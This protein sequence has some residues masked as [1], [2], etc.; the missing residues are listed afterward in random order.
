MGRCA[1][2]FPCSPGTMQILA[3][4]RIRW[5]PTICIGRFHG[6]HLPPGR[7]CRERA[8]ILAGRSALWAR[9]SRRRETF[10]REPW[11]VAYTV[12]TRHSRREIGKWLFEGSL[13]RSAHLLDP[14]HGAVSS[15][16]KR[17]TCPKP[18]PPTLENAR[19]PG[20]LVRCWGF[21]S[22]DTLERFIGGAPDA[23]PSSGEQRWRTQAHSH[24]AS[25]PVTLMRPESA[26][27]SQPAQ[28]SMAKEGFSPERPP[29]PRGAGS[30]AHS[31]NLIPE[32]LVPRGLVGSHD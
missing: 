4:M 12:E 28:W 15:F 7:E 21:P 3:T 13:Q 1:A 27:V 14:A 8:G 6:T 31:E 18:A 22:L 11:H 23:A 32:M 2:G 24:P 25:G 20:A 10:S 19:A 26:D 9:R 30:P 17:P 16:P 29:F 5:R